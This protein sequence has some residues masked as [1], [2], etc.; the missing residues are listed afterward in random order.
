MGPSSQNEKKT[1]S[2]SEKLESSLKRM[3]LSTK[4][5]LKK[6]KKNLL[7]YNPS[8]PKLRQMEVREVQSVSLNHG[9]YSKN[10]LSKKLDYNKMMYTFKIIFY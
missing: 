2:I 5:L 10:F 1:M 8:M 6:S 9:N 7:D 3:E 4:N